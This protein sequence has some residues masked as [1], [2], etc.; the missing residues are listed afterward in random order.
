MSLSGFDDRF[1][2]LRD[3]ILK[4]TEWIWEGRGID[5]I[6]DY[7]AEDCPVKTPAAAFCGVEKVILGTLETLQ[8]FPDRTLLG[9]DVIDSEDEP[10]TY[11]SSHRIFSHMTHLGEGTFGAPTG[12]R[13][14]VM[15]IADCLCRGNRIVDEWL[16][17]D[18]AGLALQLGHSPETM[19]R[20]LADKAKLPAPEALVD[21]WRGPEGDLDIDTLGPIAVRYR[22]L[23]Q[24]S[25]IEQL[26]N[27]YDRAIETKVPGARTLRGHDDLERFWF[28]YKGAFPSG[29]FR[30]HH[31]IDREDTGAARRVAFR[32]SLE[33]THQGNGAFGSASGAPVVLLGITHAELRGDT[34]VREWHMLDEIAIHAQIAQHRQQE[35]S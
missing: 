6:S 35:A 10:G 26:R 20:N 8:E 12:I 29:E 14:E 1:D 21:R 9:E 4:I 2:D 32:W 7:Y 24:H 3:Y 17:R 23:W 25:R 13:A 31:W 28:A 5:L 27:G 16:V 18:Q 15:T 30:I 22:D 19:G 33:T 11:Y 34:V